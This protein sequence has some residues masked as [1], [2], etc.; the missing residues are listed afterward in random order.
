[1]N[2]WER[3]LQNT[4]QYLEE[5]VEYSSCWADENVTYDQSLVE[6]ERGLLEGWESDYMVETVRDKA[7]GPTHQYMPQ[8]LLLLCLVDGLDHVAQIPK[9]DAF[10]V[11]CLL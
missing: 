2:K 11:Y 3:S 7:V 1:M 4:E 9:V 10:L 8:V 5:V 6:A